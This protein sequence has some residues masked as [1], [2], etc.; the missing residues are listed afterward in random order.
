MVE[1]YNRRMNAQLEAMFSARGRQIVFPK[2]GIVSQTRDAQGKKINAT[3]G[4][5]TYEGQPLFLPALQ[6]FLQVLPKDSLTY[7]SSFGKKEL[8]EFW[9]KKIYRQNPS[10]AIA[11]ISLP[12][13]TDGL[14]HGLN[15]AGFLFADPG[16]ILVT[17]DLHWENYDLIFRDC[18]GMSVETFPLFEGEKFHGQGMKDTLKKYSR[19]SRPLLLLL[20]FPHN[21]TGYA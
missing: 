16:D 17:S 4:T 14:T 15:I 21:P 9:Q 13:V 5:A 6:H 2:Q 11:P 7:A 18:Y 8:R 19:P 10:L 20:N 3:V 12:V 1:W